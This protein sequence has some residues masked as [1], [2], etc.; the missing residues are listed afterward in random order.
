MKNRNLWIALGLLFTGALQ[1]Q[2][3]LALDK[4]IASALEHNHNLKIAQFSAEQAANRATMG[5]AGLLPTV[6]ATAGANVSQQNSNL[7]FA[8]GQT[9]DVQGAQSLS[10]NASLGV[11]QVLFAGGRLQNS[12][13][14]LK[15]GKEAAS[16]AEVQAMENTVAMVWSQYTALALLQRSVATSESLLAISG[17]R[18]ARAMQLHELGGSNTTERLAAEVDLNRDSIA[19]LDVKTQ[20]D[21]AR[22]SFAT[23]IGWDSKDFVVSE[24]GLTFAYYNYKNAV[25]ELAAKNT[26]IKLAQV[27]VA[28]AEIQNK[29]E[30]ATLFPS[31]N[32]Q[33]AYGINQSQAE[34]GFLTSSQQVGLNAGVSLQYNL[35]GGFQSR[36]QRQNAEI[37]VLKAQEQFAQV[38]ET[39]ENTF[40]NAVSVYENA[41]KIA[42]IEW[43]N[44]E[45]AKQRM[46]KVMELHDLGRASSLELR[47]AQLAWSSA[48]NGKYSALFRVINAQ[49]AIHQLLGDIQSD[50]AINHRRD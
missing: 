45:V 4:A 30:K 40:E 25:S 27:S 36:T 1:A 16:L 22:N 28:T 24:T 48:E 9:Q 23:Y 10:Q 5:N 14:L 13:K 21:A 8:T 33:G 37:E 29:L 34:A 26:A 49:I 15:K 35:F 19:Y 3:V 11:S 44:A 12:F 18:F 42:G 7:E 41:V 50:G 32:A 6:N 17:Q 47:E 43:N 2:E 39:L 46:E 31:I 38:S 20:F